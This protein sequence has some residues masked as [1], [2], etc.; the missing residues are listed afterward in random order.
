[1]PETDHNPT[2]ETP[3]PAPDASRPAAAPSPPPAAAAAPDAPPAPAE[4]APPPPPESPPATAAAAAPAAEGLATPYVAIALPLGLDRMFTYELP[5]KFRGLVRPGQR[6]T[7]PFGKGNRAMTGWVVQGVDACTLEEVKAVAELVDEKPLLSEDLIDLAFW[8]SR[9]YVTPI[10]QVFEAILPAAVKRSAGFKT[11]QIVVRTEKPESEIERI[12]SKQRRVLDCLAEGGTALAPRE[13]ARQAGC[14][15]AVI[16]SLEEKGLVRIEN[17]QIDEFARDL[18]IPLEET[19]PRHLTP[20]QLLALQRI[21]NLLV[22]G[23]FG[24]VLLHG[25]TGSGKTEVYLQAIAEVVASGQQAI[26]LVPEIA[27]TPQT[28]R[29]F[30]ERFTN[31]AVLHS[32]LTDAE[33]HR[34]WRDIAEGRADVVIGARSAV[35]APVRNLGIVV[36]DE[37]HE[38]SFKQDTAPRYN[39]RDVAIMRA[40]LVGAAVILGSAT[41]SLESYQNARS[42]EHYQEAR[43]P[44]RIGGRPLP[45]VDIIDMRREAV[46]RKGHHILSRALEDALMNAWQHQEQAIL[47]L[48]RRGFA[49]HLF[50]LRCGHVEKCPDCDVGMTYHSKPGILICHYCGRRQPPPSVCPSCSSE[51]FNYWGTGTQKIEEEVLRK[52]PEIRVGRMDADAMKKRGG[53]ERL[54]AGFAEGEI[55]ILIGTQMVAKGLDFP[56]VTVVGV[57]NADVA[58]SLPDFRANERTFQLITQVAGRAGRGP[59]GGRVFIQTFQPEHLA[60]QL[61]AKHDYESFAKDELETRR[62]R[63]YPP[64]GRLARIIV[65]SQSRQRAAEAIQTVAARLA[66]PARIAGVKILGPQPCPVAKISRFWRYHMLLKAPT[67]KALMFLWDKTRSDLATPGPVQMAIDVDPQNTM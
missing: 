5:E 31:V 52:F 64:F 43:L 8:M 4:A 67:A 49:T 55:D 14:T 42:V 29:R 58:L 46:E 27:L 2:P 60:I 6:V 45:P 21:N 63:G 26:V 16:K 24:V 28:I 34:Q 50:C 25:V 51:T 39:A 20:D 33:R 32:N 23:K 13:L 22:R 12:L 59:K 38:N 1:M 19:A 37:E 54:L 17:R 41:P 7:V 56:N 65:R 61:A 3:H 62:A 9:Y 15:V 57:V 35:F 10:G 44:H 48:N 30:R 18:F 11:V 36:I 47:F 53:H 40:N 66:E